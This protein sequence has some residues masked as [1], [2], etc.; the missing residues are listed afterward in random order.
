M[1]YFNLSNDR[2]ISR[3]FRLG[4]FKVR[5]D[6]KKWPSLHRLDAKSPDKDAGHQRGFL[7]KYGFKNFSPNAYLSYYLIVT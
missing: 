1:T 2:R 3:L 6:K 7:T 5:R 4:S